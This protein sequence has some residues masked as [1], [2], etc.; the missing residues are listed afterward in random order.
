MG[1]RGGGAEVPMD[2]MG[3]RGVTGGKGS[4][5]KGRGCAELG[6]SGSG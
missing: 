2:G 3:R 5:W 4:R 1:G 6:R